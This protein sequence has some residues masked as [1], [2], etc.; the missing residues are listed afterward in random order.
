MQS[1]TEIYFF[2]KIKIKMIWNALKVMIS[3]GFLANATTACITVLNLLSKMKK[4]LF[5]FV[6]FICRLF[7]YQN[8]EILH[9]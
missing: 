3:A 1:Y 8:V 4:S 9:Y 6:S 7:F 5:K 2:V